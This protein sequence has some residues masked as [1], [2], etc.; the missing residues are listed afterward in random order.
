LGVRKR[1][2]SQS[3]KS[4]KRMSFLCGECCV[5]ATSGIFQVLMLFD[6]KPEVTSQ[7]AT[8]SSADFS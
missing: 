8:Q 2:L 1:N 4:R 3:R 5:S 7:L 6:G